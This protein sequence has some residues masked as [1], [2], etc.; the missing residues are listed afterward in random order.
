[1]HP[2][3]CECCEVR[4]DI[5]KQDV[6]E[7]II[8]FLDVFKVNPDDFG[9]VLEQIQRHYPDAALEWGRKSRD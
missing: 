4:G 7:K 6:H 9:E 3:H 1:M 5:I 8:A 2:E